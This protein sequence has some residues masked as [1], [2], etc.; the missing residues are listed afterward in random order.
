[1]ETM[2]SAQELD[3]YA[4]AKIRAGW[5][6]F[7]KMRLVC[8]L[9]GFLGSMHAKGVFHSDMKTCNILARQNGLNQEP[10]LFLVDYDAVEFGAD[11]SFHKRVKNLTQLFLSSPIEIDAV[12][13]LRFLWSYAAKA[14][15]SDMERLR[16]R[17][18]VY[19][20]VKG[21]KILYVGF[22]GDIVEDWERPPSAQS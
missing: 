18:K 20:T 11:V 7:E 5:S 1:M 21:K 13:R 4:L 8:A 2:E 16:L 6:R 14:G 17:R 19:E 12:D 22:S 3:R 9:A 10:E 15:I